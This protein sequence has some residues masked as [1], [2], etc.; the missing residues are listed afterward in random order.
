MHSR[1]EVLMVEPRGRL[2]FDVEH[3]RCIR[4]R[5]VGL[6]C[7]S[8]THP[9]VR[10]TERVICHYSAARPA[11]SGGH[12]HC[13]P[14]PAYSR[15]SGSLR[16]NRFGARAGEFGAGARVARCDAFQSLKN[17]VIRD[18]SMTSTP[19]VARRRQ[20]WKS[21]TPR[22]EHIIGIV[23]ELTYV[24][25]SDTIV[26]LPRISCSRDVLRGRV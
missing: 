20:W 25:S 11:L 9:S 22:N 14:A 26:M 21:S 18:G 4:C 16:N 24:T 12:S 2:S 1:C 13:Q 6:G 10:Q 17:S 8:G 5:P 3:V 19:A 7:F 15:S 23:L